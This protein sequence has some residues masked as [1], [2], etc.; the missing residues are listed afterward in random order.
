[1]SSRMMSSARCPNCAAAYTPQARFC[2]ACGRARDEKTEAQ[3]AQETPDPNRSILL[4]PGRH[5]TRSVPARHL[6]KAA[7]VAPPPTVYEPPLVLPRPG[8]GLIFAVAVV[9][10]GLVWIGRVRNG[11]KPAPPRAPIVAAPVTSA[12]RPTPA[13]QRQFEAKEKQELHDAESYS[14]G[15]RA[16]AAADVLQA[17]LQD[18]KAPPP[19]SEPRPYST[20]QLPTAAKRGK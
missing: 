6:Q 9:F 10:F 1:M 15:I 5:R 2:T 20:I 17:A 7:P 4:E 16:E 8:P 12:L 14:Q 11:P 13:E 19:S 18:S 3:I